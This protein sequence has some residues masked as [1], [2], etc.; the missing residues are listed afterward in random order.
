M[1]ENISNELNS[2][3]TKIEDIITVKIVGVGGAGGNAINRMVEAGIQNVEYIAINTDAKDL[4]D[5]KA[6]VKLQVGVDDQKGLGAGADPEVGRQAVENY[7]ED[8]KELLKGTKLVFIVAGEGKGTGTGG[9]PVV[10]KIAKELGIL[11]IAIV[12]RPFSFE[13]KKKAK[14]AIEGI[15]LLENE[16]D[17]LIIIDNQKLY[18]E[19]F[20][21]ESFDE[22]FFE[23]DR[24]IR[25]GV[26]GITDIIFGTGRWHVDFN[27][28]KTV[29]ENSGTAFMG[30]GIADG[31]HRAEKAVE[32]ALNS[33]MSDVSID[34]S[35]SAFVKVTGPK[36]LSPAEIDTVF[37]YFNDRISE[38]AEFIQGIA[39]D[40]TLGDQLKVT[41]IVSGAKSSAADQFALNPASTPAPSVVLGVVS[42]PNPASPIKPSFQP[43]SATP[44]TPKVET[45]QDSLATQKF[46][47][48]AIDNLDQNVSA[49][50]FNQLKQEKE[51]K[52]DNTPSVEPV[53]TTPQPPADLFG[54]SSGQASQTDTSELKTAAID[55]IEDEEDK[56]SEIQT[57]DFL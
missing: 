43:A 6:D 10:A 26:S 38:D 5:K 17:A 32:N 52:M 44:I 23:V 55:K 19:G 42:T 3:N 11:T 48:S 49:P 51:K 35:E 20:E 54:D 34:G 39:I 47:F 2:G 8:I 41:V 14:R 40:E 29:L 37:R 56:S 21:V 1:S 27:D 53:I 50:I 24:I 31:E 15:E 25:D 4:M 36:S 18:T 7:A 57:P 16:V 33:P 9:A 46:S 22:A 30:I 28:V 45:Q 12:T 13:G